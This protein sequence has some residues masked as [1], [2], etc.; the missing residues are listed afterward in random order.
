MS[1]IQPTDPNQHFNYWLESLESIYD[2]TPPPKIPKSL[3]DLRDR[4]K[5]PQAH[6]VVRQLFA[7]LDGILGSPERE[8]L[9]P[10][11]TFTKVYRLA[12]RVLKDTTNIK[13]RRPIQKSFDSLSRVIQTKDPVS[14]LSYLREKGPKHLSTNELQQLNVFLDGLVYDQRALHLILTREVLMFVETHLLSSFQQLGG[15]TGK[16]EGE[17]GFRLEWKYMEDVGPE[18]IALSARLE[19]AIEEKQFL[20][21]LKKT[22]EDQAFF[23]PK[24]MNA[25]HLWQ[26][27]AIISAISQFCVKLDP[28]PVIVCMWELKHV[29]RSF[30][31]II[32]KMK[33]K[34]KPT[35]AMHTFKGT[36]NH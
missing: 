4:P 31:E 35:L 21:E 30:P 28:P 25:F 8:E 22:T 15:V 7:E 3:E 9:I 2:R 5:N 13:E 17:K 23:D 27:I 26:Y 33:E 36:M 20:L 1:A 29:N 10:K 6:Y 12:A 11:E 16:K 24:T 32:K 19:R 34:R 18:A 14:F